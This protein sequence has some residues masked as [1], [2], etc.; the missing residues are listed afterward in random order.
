MVAQI[1]VGV[2]AVLAGLLGLILLFH[3]T[4][5]SE[6]F[7]IAIAVVALAYMYQG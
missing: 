5:T 1:A 2:G 3:V 6:I 4:K 7:V